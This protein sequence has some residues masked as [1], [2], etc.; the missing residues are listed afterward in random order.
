MKR[1]ILGLAV[2]AVLSLTTSPALAQRGMARRY[3]GMVMTPQGPVN[4]RSPEYR[5]AGG[6]M[7]AYRQIM[8]MKQMQQQRQQYQKQVQQYQ[9]QMKQQ[10]QKLEELKKK[11]PAAYAKLEEQYQKKQ[12]AYKEYMRHFEPKA[13]TVKSST[14]D[15]K[16]AETGQAAGFE[17][18]EIKPLEPA[19]D[20]SKANG[21]G[22][23]KAKAK[24]G[25]NKK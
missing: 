16:S 25:K 5:M 13:R 9:K 3:R 23:T 21:S 6:N 10:K 14:D 22:K 24:T 1:I 15:K 4:T 18:A 17:T 19:A 11:D 7:Q 20:D 12:E 2:L 8:A